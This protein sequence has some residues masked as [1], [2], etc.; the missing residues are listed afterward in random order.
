M[1][2][3]IEIDEAAVAQEVEGIA[4]TISEE[5]RA[6]LRNRIFPIIKGAPIRITL[7]EP[8]GSETKPLFETVNKRELAALYALVNYAAHNQNTRPET[9]QERVETRFDVPHIGL[10]VRGDFHKAVAYLLDMHL[11]FV[12]E[13]D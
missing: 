3:T 6:T 4:E 9:V 5:V 7:F 1:N 13:S 10:I 8:F 11:M 12:E 2:K